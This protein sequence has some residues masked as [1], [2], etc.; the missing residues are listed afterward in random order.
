MISPSAVS[1]FYLLRAHTAY[2][3][4]ARLVQ[5]CHFPENL[6]RSG[7]AKLAHLRRLPLPVRGYPR[8]P[9]DH[10]P[11]RAINL[12]KKKAQSDQCPSTFAQGVGAMIPTLFRHWAQRPTKRLFPFFFPLRPT[13][14]LTVADIWLQR[15]DSGQVVRL[16]RRQEI[17][18][19]R[20]NHHSFYASARSE[21]VR[22][23]DSG[24]H[25][26]SSQSLEGPCRGRGEDI[27]LAVERRDQTVDAIVLQDGGEF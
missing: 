4:R 25:F 5:L 18:V 11:D 8:I 15:S 27:G 12:R 23:R 21:A 14:F 16:S 9:V 17:A 26:K 13:L 20:H 7:R 6:L 3:S 10:G 2:R 1:H 19:F 22:L 24:R